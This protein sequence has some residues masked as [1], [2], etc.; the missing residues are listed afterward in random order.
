MADFNASHPTGAA[1]A[2]AAAK[3][4]QRLSPPLQASRRRKHW[5]PAILT[6]GAFVVAAAALWFTGSGI[7]R[8]TAQPAHKPAPVESEYRW[9]NPEV[10]GDALRLLPVVRH[11]LASLPAGSSV[12]DLGCGNG[13][14]L[15][16]FRDRGWKLVGVDMSESGI[17]IARQHWPSI[18][19]IDADVTLP[20]S[21]VE[22]NSFDAVLTTD[23]IEHVFAPRG[24]ASNCFRL[25]KPGGRAIIA[26]PYHG[27]LKDVAIAVTNSWDYHV[28]PLWDFGHIK[29]WS[30][31]TM[32]TLLFEAGFENLEWQGVGRA[33]Y[34]WR[35]MIF[36][37]RRPL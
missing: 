19:F 13:S 34:L 14:V 3:E 18:R 27:Y 9:S 16:S 25:L 29:F 11:Y 7:H 1:A 12:I 17:A 37:A 28:N 31:D 23:V 22:Y 5:K 30:V 4:D 20:I 10:T 35:E 32:S 33:P 24:M 21:S 8:I 15:A 26:T 2:R 6:C 36:E